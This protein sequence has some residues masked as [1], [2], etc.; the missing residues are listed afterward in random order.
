MWVL[1]IDRFRIC[2]WPRIECDPV[3]FQPALLI[4]PDQL[5]VVGQPSNAGGGVGNNAV[6]GLDGVI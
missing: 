2:F 3:L 5:E 6:A 4:D 1:R